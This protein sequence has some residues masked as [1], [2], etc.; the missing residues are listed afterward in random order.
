MTSPV[1]PD[2]KNNYLIDID[3]TITDDIPNEKPELMVDPK[4][5]DQ[6]VEKLNKKYREGHII[7]IFTS[8]TEEHRKVTEEWLNN[9]G[10]LYHQ[11]LMNKPRGGKYIWVDNHKVT[12]VLF[13]GSWENLEL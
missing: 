4:P 13:N 8:R 3:G 7:T 6:S 1:L 12:G 2:G 9:H 11:L 10:Y 5:F